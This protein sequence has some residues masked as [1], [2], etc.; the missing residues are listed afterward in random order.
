MKFRKLTNQKIGKEELKKKKNIWD[1]QKRTKEMTDSSSTILVI[2]LNVN[3][4]HSRY[5]TKIIKLDQTW[6]NNKLFPKDIPQIWE[7]R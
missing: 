1:R 2:T 5:N 6:P 4:K 7:Y 3:N